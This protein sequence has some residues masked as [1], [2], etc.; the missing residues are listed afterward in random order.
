MSYRTTGRLLITAGA[1]F[2]STFLSTGTFGHGLI[3][4]P[5][6]R[7][8]F[9]GVITKPNEAGTPQA[10]YP[11]CAQ[12]F[13][14][15][16]TQGYNF[17]SVLTHH[18]GRL[19]P[20][21][22]LS[23]PQTPPA[24]EAG[25]VTPPLAQH[26]CSYDSESFDGNPTVWDQPIDWPT[27][28][29]QAGRNRFTWNISWG[30]HFSD[31]QEFHY[32]ITKPGFQFTVGTPLAWSDFEAQP[33]CQLAFDRE[34]PGANPDI[35]ARVDDAKFDTFCDVP[36]RSGRHVIYAE[37]GRNY[38]TWERF[39]G[40]VD[41]VF[42]G[43]GTPIDADISVQPAGALSG[44]GSVVLDASG[45]IGNNLTYSWQ[46]QSQTT[47]AQYT[48]ADPGAAISTLSFTDPSAAGSVTVALTVSAG[49]QSSV[50]TAVLE[51]LPQT[52]TSAWVFEQ[53][54]TE[55][56][57]L[58]AG[59]R[60]N[61]RLVLGDGTDVFLPATPLVITAANSA[62][63]AWPAALAQ[64]VNA[65]DG[66]VR[67]GV[68]NS[69]DQVVPAPSATANNVYSKVTADVASVFL[70]VEPAPAPGNCAYEVVSEWNTGFSG[71]IVIS[72]TGTTAIEGWTVNWNYSDGTVLTEVWNAQSSG[73]YTATNLSWNATIAPGA[74]VEFG[75]NGTKGGATAE[76]PAVTGSVCQ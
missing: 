30:P 29:L 23:P 68:L 72:N 33:F 50:E 59:D 44:A 70:Q 25:G 18:R 49:A 16:G 60:V 27:N 52:A 55:A 32:W 10:Q 20:L 15:L 1:F 67:I 58:S 12:A 74:S 63:D 56:R 73:S 76:L 57:T 17:M 7:N 28:N 6:A 69:A 8:H 22:P 40:C 37:W 42:G 62:A 35:V 38:F 5:S 65:L 75:F 66:E 11:V 71:K 46:V 4:S 51:H 31:T 9:C 19:R 64:A 14:N 53:V 34:N 48:I 2:L 43:G 13:E 24:N 26:V 21:P 47:D 41:V 39:H 45:S 3:E 54:L 61:I 36:Q